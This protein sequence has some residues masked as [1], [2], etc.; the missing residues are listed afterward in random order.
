MSLGD[1]Q[2]IPQLLAVYIP[3]A[4]E[5][6]LSQ[7]ISKFGW[8]CQILCVKPQI[9]STSDIWVVISHFLLLGCLLTAGASLGIA[10]E[11]RGGGASRVIEL[12]G[13][14][15]GWASSVLPVYPKANKWDLFLA[16]ELQS[17]PSKDR[18]FSPALEPAPWG[19]PEISPELLIFHLKYICIQ[20]YY[21]HI[22]Y[23]QTIQD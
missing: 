3:T 1:S 22:I 19:I 18:R 21:I 12:D 8:C 9:T 14:G 2:D 6:P 10:T 23:I 11:T 20:T 17:I 4:V 16:L 15:G 7:L 5:H 13:T